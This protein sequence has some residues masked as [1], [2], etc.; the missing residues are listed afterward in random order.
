MFRCSI[1]NFKPRNKASQ[2]RKPT[3]K[4]NP[5]PWVVW[6]PCLLS[7][8]LAQGCLFACHLVSHQLSP[9]GRRVAHLDCCSD[10][11]WEGKW[12]FEYEEKRKF[13]D[14]GQVLIFGYTELTFRRPITIVQFSN[15]APSR[16]LTCDLG[17]KSHL[18]WMVSNSHKHATACTCNKKQMY[19]HGLSICV[20]VFYWII[21]KGIRF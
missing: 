9:L 11:H 2:A 12:R 7:I 6:H 15:C 16:W 21:Y 8:A 4:A 19:T 20:L 14:H 13:L 18:K 10:W 17:L 3:T 1:T 5:S